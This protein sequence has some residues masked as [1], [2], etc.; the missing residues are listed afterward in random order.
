VAG[1][2]LGS[3]AL[4]AYLLRRLRSKRLATPTTEVVVRIVRD[5]L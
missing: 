4:S 5:D 2:V 3:A 1:L